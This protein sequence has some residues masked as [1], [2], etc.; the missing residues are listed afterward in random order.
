MRFSR[1]TGRIAIVLTVLA[2]LVTPAL[3]YAHARLVKASPEV[4]GR[5]VVVPTSL[6][7]WFSE[8][9]EPSFTKLE[10]LDSA[11]TA[12]PLGPVTT[13][14]GDAMGV[15]A[16][17]TGTVA[18]GKYTVSWRTAA[19]DGHPTTGRYSFVVALLP[20]AVPPT[21]DTG[22]KTLPVQKPVSNAVV[23]PVET[24][25]FSTSTRW[26]ELV[27]LLTLIGVAIFRL[28]VITPADAGFSAD[29][30]AD[31]SDRARR[32]AQAVLILFLL[33]A[34]WRL[35]AQA[36]LLVDQVSSRA[37][38]MMTVIRASQW[39]RGWLVGAL[40]GVVAGVGLV[41]ARRSNSGWIVAGL[42]IVAICFG[43]G[44][45]GHAGALRN[46][47]SLATAID[48]AHLLGAGGWLGGLAAVLLCGLPATGRLPETERRAAGQRLVRSY[49][50]AAVECV[51][52]VLITAVFAAWLRFSAFSDLWVTAYGRILLL[53]LA[54]AI[55]LLGIGWYHWRNVVTPE[56]DDDTG[57]RFKRSAAVELLVGAAVLGATAVLVSTALPAIA[58]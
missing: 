33:T 56:W 5:V 53:K 19:A 50:K 47:A 6:S 26:V 51:A 40:G 54:L 39:G 16:P 14:A 3:V 10:L 25:V 8:K 20:A 30:F 58:S 21:V 11:G 41:L 27:S 15:T 28:F 52:L 18:N 23:A 37:A 42:G 48:L 57:F 32:L 35:S 49:H 24:S 45:T 7:L 31:A 9:P 43:E 22:V 38:A 55:V 29:V 46:R 36:E 4:N 34:L 44:I 2:V 17:I 1:R 13:I 12:V